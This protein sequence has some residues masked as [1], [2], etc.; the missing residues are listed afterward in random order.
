MDTLLFILLF[1]AEI[2]TPDAEEIVREAQLLLTDKKTDCS[3]L[4]FLVP[5]VIGQGDRI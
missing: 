4:G 5:T 3:F 1:E 2:E